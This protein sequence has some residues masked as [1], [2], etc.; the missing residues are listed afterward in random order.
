MGSGMVAIAHGV[1]HQTIF[2]FYLDFMFSLG[3]QCEKVSLVHNLSVKWYSHVIYQSLVQRRTASCHPRDPGSTFH[4][5]SHLKQLTP[6][7]EPYA[8][9][10]LKMQ[11]FDPERQK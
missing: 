2:G 5:P 11:P 1:E 7:T 8:E 3:Y 6:S 9:Q 4:E 10:S